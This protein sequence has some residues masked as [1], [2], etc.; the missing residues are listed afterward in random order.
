MK[1]DKNIEETFKMQDAFSYM[2]PQLEPGKYQTN[3]NFKFP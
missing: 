3:S 1:S 2:E